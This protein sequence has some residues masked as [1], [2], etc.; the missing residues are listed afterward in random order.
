MSKVP[1]GWL[2]CFTPSAFIGYPLFNSPNSWPAV[3][4]ILFFCLNVI[5]KALFFFLA[6][7]V[8]PLNNFP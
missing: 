1:K 4:A 7:G 8:L 3:G 5:F 6:K 2:S